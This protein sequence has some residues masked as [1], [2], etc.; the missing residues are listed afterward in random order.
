ML[1][2]ISVRAARRSIRRRKRRRRNRRSLWTRRS[3][4][5]KMDLSRSWRTPTR[6]RKCTRH[7]A[8]EV[9][10]LWFAAS[11]PRTSMS[12]CAPPRPPLC[13]APLWTCTATVS[14][15]KRRETSGSGAPH[16]LGN[17]QEP[18]Y[19]RIVVVTAWCKTSASPLSWQRRY[20]SLTLS[21]ITCAAINTLITHKGRQQMAAIL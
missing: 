3:W 15:L 10:C 11:F 16:A 5:T 12:A 20:Q 19:D 8:P 13:R 1:I 6:A 21:Y 18:S 2:S 7:L 17:E 14:W 9:A 4:W